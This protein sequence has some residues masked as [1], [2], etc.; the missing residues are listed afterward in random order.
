M[1]ACKQRVKQCLNW[2]QV[3]STF[4]MPSHYALLRWE[5]LKLLQP[6]E[7]SPV[8]PLILLGVSANPVVTFLAACLGHEDGQP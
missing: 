5:I 2:R 3:A 6:L 4:S 8:I 1:I 7:I